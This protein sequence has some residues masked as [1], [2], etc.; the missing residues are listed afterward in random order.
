MQVVAVVVCMTEQ[1]DLHL[2]EWEV[3]VAED[4]GED[5]H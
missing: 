2:V 1:V 4:Q 3:S 5:Q